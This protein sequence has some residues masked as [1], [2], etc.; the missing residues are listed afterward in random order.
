MT[1]HLSADAPVSVAPQKYLFGPFIDFFMLGGSAFLLLPIL[2]LVP[3]KHE[4]LVAGVTLLL[5]NLIN[6]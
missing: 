2:F 1:L 3:L 6:P 4:G 5:A